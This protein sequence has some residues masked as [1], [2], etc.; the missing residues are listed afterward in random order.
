[1]VGAGGKGAVMQ[2][3]LI[4][5]NDRRRLEC[6]S[7]NAKHVR[8]TEFLVGDDEV[9]LYRHSGLV[10]HVHT[11]SHPLE[12]LAG[13]FRCATCQT[14]YEPGAFGFREMR[15]RPWGNLPTRRR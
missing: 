14:V 13:P 10:I 15:P 5:W 3:E 8:A 12:R 4:L 1:M 2:K 6:G 9:T 7:C 11:G